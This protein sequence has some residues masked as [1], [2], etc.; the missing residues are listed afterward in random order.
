MARSRRRGSTRATD[1]LIDCARALAARP[2]ETGELVREGA[3]VVL[4]GAPNVGKSSLFNALLGQSR[5]IVTEIPGTTRDAIE[6][7]IDT[8]TLPLR[9]VDTAGLRDALDPVERI[10]VRG[11]RVVR[12]ARGGRARVCRQRRRRSMRAA[13]ALGGNECCADGRRAD[14]ERRA[15]PSAS[16]LAARARQAEA[17]TAVSVSA[18]TGCGARALLSDVVR[19]LVRRRRFAATATRRSS[20]TSDTGTAWPRA[21][22]GA[23]VSRAVGAAA[24]CRRP[25]AAVHLREAVHDARG[26]RRRDRRRGHARRSISAFLRREVNLE[27]PRATRHRRRLR[28]APRSRRRWRARPTPIRSPRWPARTSA[29]RGSNPPAREARSDRRCAPRRS[30]RRTDSAVASPGPSDRDRSA[31]ARDSTDSSWRTSA[32]WRRP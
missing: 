4:A 19:R 9:L 8:P 18:E 22:R 31:T 29:R 5:A 7:V 32:Y 24:T 11:E 17:S 26:S 13:H 23:R 16:E 12:R 30:C 6:A 1:E 25:V 20:R 2:R 3:L 27:A 10:G 14:E 21:R 15:P 28:R